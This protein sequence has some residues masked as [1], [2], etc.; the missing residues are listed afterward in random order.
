MMYA[1]T[2]DVYYNELASSEIVR[3][4]QFSLG[5]AFNLYCLDRD[6]TQREKEL[7]READFIIAGWR[8]LG[9]QTINDAVQLKGIHKLGSGIEKI[10]VKTAAEKGIPITAATGS[11]APQVAEHTIMLMLAVLRRLCTVDAALRRGQWNKDALRTTLRSL[12]GKRVGI[13]G[14]GKVGQSVASRLIPFN[15]SLSFF[16]VSTNTDQGAREHRL[17]FLG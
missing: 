15:C 17:Q 11:N 14:M 1:K 9:A 4:I 2:I 7:A 8:P 3:V 10:D 13:V 16:D 12:E 6:D 5:D